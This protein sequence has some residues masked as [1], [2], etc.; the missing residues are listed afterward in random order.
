MPLPAR[1]PTN[2]TGRP[3]SAATAAVRHD[4]ANGAIDSNAATVLAPLVGAA[5]GQAET[6][7]R[8]ALRKQHPEAGRIEAEAMRWQLL[9]DAGAAVLRRGAG[10][11]EGR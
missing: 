8:E 9:A 11:V 2:Q 1:C 4:L 6:L 7:R 3:G 10:R 5:A